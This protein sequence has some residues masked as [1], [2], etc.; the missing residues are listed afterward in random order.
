MFPECSILW[1]YWIVLNLK[2][3]RTNLNFASI[4]RKDQRPFHS[5]TVNVQLRE[6]KNWAIQVISLT[7][8]QALSFTDQPCVHKSLSEAWSLSF[9]NCGHLINWWHHRDWLTVKDYECTTSRTSKSN[10]ERPKMFWHCRPVLH[11]V[12]L[13]QL[14]FWIQRLRTLH[15]ACHR[16]TRCQPTSLKHLL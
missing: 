6:V 15:C 7:S 9:L 12:A 2:L 8:P 5:C 13:L 11:R 1:E 16:T 14:R 4:R 3:Q 10:T